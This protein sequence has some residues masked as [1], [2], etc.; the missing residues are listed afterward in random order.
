M[1]AAMT[2]ITCLL[3]GFCDNFDDEN[4]WNSTV[5]YY[6]SEYYW[7]FVHRSTHLICHDLKNVK[8]VILFVF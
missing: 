1:Y 2:T 3:L 4:F 8:E 7:K 6:L 5:W